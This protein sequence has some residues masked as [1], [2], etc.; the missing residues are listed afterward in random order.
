[1]GKG[2][3]RD[4]LSPALGSGFSRL[5]QVPDDVLGPT[6]TRYSE[7]GHAP[8]VRR[9]AVDAALREALEAGGPPY[10]FVVLVG[11]AASGKS[12][13]AVEGVRALFADYG[14][15]PVVI[16]PHNGWA[17]ADLMFRDPPLRA[18]SPAVVWLDDLAA[19]DLAAWTS[20]VLDRVAEQAILVA[21]TTTSR[22]EEIAR[23]P[24]HPIAASWTAVWRAR[25]VDLPSTLEADELTE[26]RRLYPGEVF[27][28]SIAR[29][30][31]GGQELLD[32]YLGARATEPAGHALVQAAVDIR[33]A[34]VT[35]P[36]TRHE[37]W[38]LF[39]SYLRRVRA[40]AS[41]TEEVF[42]RAFRW[43]ADPVGSQVPL[44][45]AVEGGQRWQI[46]DY[47][48]CAEDGQYGGEV[49]PI[50]DE[51]WSE[52]LEVVPADAVVDMGF[53]AI[54]RGR[55]SVAAQVW[56]TA[57]EAPDTD[58]APRAAFWLGVLLRQHGYRRGARTAFERAVDSGHP[59]VA[60]G[61]KAN[62]GGLLLEE[63]DQTGAR[64]A[65]QQVID[66]GHSDHAPNA[67]NNLGVLFTQRGNSR[68]ARK[69]FR[70]AIDS[71]HG[72][73]APMAAASL[74]L[75]LYDL[76]DPAGARAAYQLAVDS[77]HPTAAPLA[78]VNLS[79]LLND[80]DDPHQVRAVFR[81]VIES[82]H[83]DLTPLAAFSVG[84]QLDEAG[85]PERARAA[86]Q[87]AID[88]GH[89]DQ[90]PKAA[91]RLGVLLHEQDDPAG[92]RA[93]YQTAIDSSHIDH[94]PKAWYGLGVLLR[95]YGDLDGARAAYQQAID[96][97]HADVAPSAAVNLGLLL[98]DTGDLAGARAAY[99]RAIDSGHPVVAPVARRLYND[100]ATT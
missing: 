55:E 94:A 76:G 22:W 45:R 9:P 2:G 27:G 51:T 42:H 95:Q 89:R 19:A 34:G 77:G 17:L 3:A 5:S 30:L 13:T 92:A 7:A 86:Y 16:I 24:S 18:P 58:A 75:L 4:N 46:L 83:P 59:F 50:P 26:A 69:A 79:L 87:L 67:A 25:R 81:Q 85:D 23:S 72:D 60:L 40:D 32:R 64:R 49:R 21:T 14:H 91:H 68:G 20:T 33:R 35:R 65:F 44:L 6:P 57:S 39:P 15:D 63:G 28:D 37:L 8:Y 82:G 99:Q 73:C 80:Q 41:P 78:A 52:L 53:E 98:K 96:S 38:H 71:G 29:T 74:G 88:S 62:V 97:G 54:L 1:L 31:V 11:E 93:A 48:A 12:R 100:L 90:A 61:A 70:M 43:A 10:P 66:S 84:V 36:V 56:R 47:V